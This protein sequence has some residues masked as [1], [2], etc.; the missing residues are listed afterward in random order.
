MRQNPDSSYDCTALHRAGAARAGRSWAHGGSARAT[1]EQHGAVAAS[2]VEHRNDCQPSQRL[3][4]RTSTFM[5]EWRQKTSRSWRQVGRTQAKRPT[6]MRGRWTGIRAPAELPLST[7]SARAFAR[8]CTQ[9]VPLPTRGNSWRGDLGRHHHRRV[10]GT[11][12]CRR[13]QRRRPLVR[14]RSSTTLGA[15]SGNRWCR[16]ADSAPPVAPPPG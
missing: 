14:A 9:G 6:A 11:D 7:A 8:R 5:S 4:T 10:T 13:R 15:R 16:P 2:G 1:P 3:P 12:L